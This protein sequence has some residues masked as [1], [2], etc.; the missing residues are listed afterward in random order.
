MSEVKSNKR[1]SLPIGRDKYKTFSS[2]DEY[3]SFVAEE[4]KNWEWLK[5]HSG[6]CS[7]MMREMYSQ[8]FQPQF[9][10]V[11]SNDDS[12]STLSKL[13]SSIGS[14]LPIYSFTPDGKF[15]LECKK[16]HGAVVA[17]MVIFYLVY[18]NGLES[19]G[20]A[21]SAD[22]SSNQDV[23]ALASYLAFDFKFGIRGN[24][25]S[26]SYSDAL[27]DAHQHYMAQAENMVSEVA[28]VIESTR[29]MKQEEERKL[30]KQRTQQKTRFKQTMSHYFLLARKTKEK[31]QQQYDAAKADV[32]NAKAAYHEQVDLDASVSYWESRSKSNQRN[33]FIWAV[34]TVL[35]LIGTFWG[36]VK[37]YT[38]GGL[39]G[40]AAA[41]QLQTQ[42]IQGSEVTSGAV[43]TLT[44]DYAPM[45]GLSEHLVVNITGTALLVT[46]MAVIIR[47][48]LR[49]FNTYSHLSLESA[50]RITMVKT[51][52][53]LL[54]E[55][56]LKSDQD[57]H[58]ALDA[59]FRSSQTGMIAETSFN[60]PVDI[61]LKTVAEKAGK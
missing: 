60:S 20:R 7:A 53:A 46:L 57:R 14:Y 11:N 10:V 25:Q 18:K 2:F 58:L 8:V 43:S 45:F 33:A 39:S 52:L 28:N 38:S 49:Q 44:S 24:G 16:K 50:E 37:Y 29:Q 56:K 48:C 19:A 30:E 34:L 12:T 42:N 5:N 21:T 35:S 1:F 27:D 23:A 61:V 26:K 22:F 54:N 47:M 15:V 32:E 41:H 3:K 40:L 59:L 9:R 4:I 36:V 51:Y 13:E 55:G 31:L 6:K 17:G